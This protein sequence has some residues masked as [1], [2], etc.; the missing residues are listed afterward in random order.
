MVLN[1]SPQY[2]QYIKYS[3]LVDEDV[4]TFCLFAKYLPRK[5]KVIARKCTFVRLSGG[6]TLNLIEETKQA[7]TEIEM[8]LHDVVKC[9]NEHLRNK[10]SLQFCQIAVVK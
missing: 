8:R 6:S 2:N 5:L 7:G 1:S 4:K 3:N 9:I 10:I